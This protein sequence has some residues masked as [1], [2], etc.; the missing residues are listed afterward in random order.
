MLNSNHITLNIN[1]ST[2]LPFNQTPQPTSSDITIASADLH[3]STSWQTIHSLTSDHLPL[4]SDP[5]IHHKIKITRFYFTKI[6]TNYRKTDRKLFKQHVEVLFS[7]RFHN[8]NV[9]RLTNTLSRQFWMLTHSSSLAQITL[10]YSCIS[11][12]LCI[13]V[14]I[15]ANKTDQTHKSLLLTIT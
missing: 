12:S 3:D 8:T 10:T 9:Q 4:L 5:S 11:T 6:L 14:T 13:I 7:Y 15:F 1:T 2:R